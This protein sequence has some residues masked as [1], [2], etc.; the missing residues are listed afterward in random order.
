MTEV[1]IDS[2]FVGK[3][4]D[5]K[6]F[7]EQIKTERRVN[8]LSKE[9]NIYYDQEND[10]IE[11]ETE[12]GR[13]RRP[14]IIVENGESKIK[15]EHIESLEK[16]E[17]TWD[18]LIQQGLIEYLDA[19]EE[20]NALV[21]FY[22]KELTP[23]HTHLEIAPVAMLG[24]C[25]SLVPFADHN[26]ATKTHGGSK[27]QKQALGFYAAN[28]P[29]RIDTDVSLLHYPQ[30]PIVK[31]L[32]YDIAREDEHP[33]GNNVIVAVMS[34][35]GYNMDDSIIINKSSVERGLARSTYFRP[36]VSEELRYSGGLVD[37]IG[38]IDKDV[39]GYKTEHDYRYLGDDGICYPEAKVSEEDVLV[40]KTSPPRFLSGMDEY[41]LAS[42]SRRESSTA[43][44]HGE[45]GIVDFVVIT[46]NGEGNK[47]IQI[48]VREA[49]IPEIGDKFSSRHGQKGIIGMLYPASDMPFSASGIIPDIVFSPHSIPSRMTIGHLIEIVG[50]K[51]GCLSGRN[52]DG[53]IFDGETETN[54]RKELLSLGFREDG[55][56]TLYNGLTGDKFK[57]KIFIGNQYYMK[58][59]YMVAGKIQSR[60]TGPVALLT[61]QPTEGKAKEGG[62]KLGEMEKDTL[63]AHGASLLLKERFDSDKTIVPVC[64]KS[65]LIG[66]YDARKNRLISPIY[67]EESEMEYVEMSYAF[68]LLL[69]ELKSMMIYPELR[70]EDLY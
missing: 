45:H 14:L 32:T 24:L 46:E 63:V 54:I 43:I 69:D 57:V 44:R 11:V 39:K 3:V 41:T 29:L 55:T 51:V 50:G 31:S 67:G 19:A 36:Y 22:E 40:G 52:V 37:E 26:M 61:R 4:E 30:V 17:L 20:E 8:N 64:K 13:L 34:Y 58:L 65:G 68:K 25:T 47:Y 62:L 33:A 5:P 12:K 18:S 49:R 60:A 6:L 7:V 15:K 9:I 16:G 70:L 2:M 53:T 42:S 59:K 48:R 35:E 27:G 21:A 10:Q 38:P 28:F 23:A 66:Y 1:Y 56:E